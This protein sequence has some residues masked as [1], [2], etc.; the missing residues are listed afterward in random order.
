[1]KSKSKHTTVAG[2]KF[3]YCADFILRGMVATNEET[4]EEKIIIKHGYASTDLTI[5]K[6]IANTFE[7]STF[8]TK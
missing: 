6:A 3:T 7:L 2:I 4:G 8:R 5:R 1:M